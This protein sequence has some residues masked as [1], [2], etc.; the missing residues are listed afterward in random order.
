M[1]TSAD[2]AEPSSQPSQSSRPP[3]SAPPS[4]PAAGAPRPGG[5]REMLGIAVP[6]IAS[7]ACETVMT[8]TDRLFL[9]R[10]GPE[11]MSAAMAGGLTAFLLTTFFI[12]L[13]GYTTALVAQYL[14]A[15]QRDRCALAL[16]QA[17]LVA[18]AA[19]PLML[20]AR[21]LGHAM[22]EIAKVA[23]E[24][25]EPQKRYFDI[26][27]WGSVVSLLRNCLGGFFSG[28]GRTR[29]VMVAS[30]TAMVANIVG[31]YALIFGRLGFPALGIDGAAWG[32]IFGGTC[33][34]AVLV[35]GYL[36]P[37]IRAEFGVGRSL[38]Y[39]HTAMTRLLRFGYPAGIEF[40]LNLLAFDMLVLVFHSRGLEAATAFTIVFNW[41]MVS[42]VPLI[43]VN[44]GVTSLVGRYMGAGDPDTAHR[45][46][47]S[48]LKLAWLYATCTMIAFSCFTGPLVDV[49]RPPADAD[50]FERARP[51]A[52]TM[53]RLT[54]IYVLADAMNLVFSGALRGAGDTLWA[55]VISVGLHWVLVAILIAMLNLLGVSVET[56][57]M[58]LVVLILIFSGVFF[59]RYR[60][61]AWRKIRIVQSADDP[62]QPPPVLA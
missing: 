57:W 33:G 48:G 15:G 38:R 50:I 45:S 4:L 16:T 62:T 26:L 10:L 20:A 23:P 42:F 25:M 43:G 40:F 54:S 44:V 55:M 31:N 7:S 22:F 13:T 8:F 46:T 37:A 6:M 27:L 12:G 3:H 51:M 61:G 17:L 21:P 52:V 29:I 30:L 49:F 1:T 59:L 39:D 41:D 28:I 60:S 14:G 58:A 2:P 53:L 32:T 19:Y 5:M 35:A 18:L 34:L 36:R 56:A 24:Q 9:S 11:H 47:M